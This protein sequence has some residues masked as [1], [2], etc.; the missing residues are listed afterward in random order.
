[1]RISSRFR[2]MAEVH[3]GPNPSILQ[4][5]D[6]KSKVP[7]RQTSSIT[8]SRSLPCCNGRRLRRRHKVGSIQLPL[9]MASN[10]CSSL[11][12]LSREINWTTSSNIEIHSTRIVNCCFQIREMGLKGRGEL[13]GDLESNTH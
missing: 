11:K 1:M 12:A 6:R 7:R 2:L 4:K 9:V 10:S 5:G 13:G 8:C 3:T